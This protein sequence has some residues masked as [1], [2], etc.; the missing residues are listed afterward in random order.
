MR[1]E[2]GIGVSTFHC[3]RWPPARRNVERPLTCKAFTFPGRCSCDDALPPIS[4]NDSR[5]KTLSCDKALLPML[6]LDLKGELREM[7]CLNVVKN[8]SF[9]FLIENFP[10][11]SST[12]VITQ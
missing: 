7:P 9:F 10:Q 8:Q 1:K 2:R 3:E 12:A 11:Q 5:M 4:G 6:P